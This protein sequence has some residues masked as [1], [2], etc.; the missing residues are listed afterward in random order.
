MMH[1][2][3]LLEMMIGQV[4]QVTI[5]CVLMGWLSKSSLRSYSTLCYYLS[6]VVLVKCITP[7]IWAS[8]CG[9]FSWLFQHISD[10]S[11]SRMPS[12]FG[13]EVT[14]DQVVVWLTAI[15]LTGFVGSLARVAITWALLRRKIASNLVDPSSEL[16]QRLSRLAQQL[17]IRAHVK[18]IVTRHSAGP[19]VIGYFRPILV[20]PFELV[21]SKSIDELEPILAHELLHIRRGD[22]AVAFLET[23]VRSFWWFHPQ[24]QATAD[25]VSEMGEFCCD[26][27]VL[28]KLK[29]KPRRY[30]DALIA[31]LESRF[32]LQPLL[33]QPGIRKSQVTRERLL[34]VMQNKPKTARFTL[35]LGLLILAGLMIL[36]GRRLAG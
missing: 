31:V 15:W 34:C 24:V 14:S 5:L 4:W 20:L 18:L 1:A 26:Q 33:G 29:Y 3:T 17:K 22:T 16:Q 35:K 13:A 30:A 27:D 8:H 9:V 36:P 21:Q 12:I 32:Q 2:E 23:I 11:A 6:L 10:A 7:P 25:M 28:E 19:A